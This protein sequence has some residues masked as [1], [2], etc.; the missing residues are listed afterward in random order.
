MFR[1]SFQSKSLESHIARTILPISQ[2]Y[3]TYIYIY[4]KCPEHERTFR[5][6]T[7]TDN[8]IERE[9]VSNCRC[10]NYRTPQAI[11][12]QELD[13]GI[14]ITRKKVEYLGL[15]KTS[16][17]GLRVDTDSRARKAMDAPYV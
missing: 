5:K 2:G 17:L 11:K 8:A 15:S 9:L 10:N 4:Y 1:R 12:F 7:R 3:S 16:R 13:G 6:K 14:E